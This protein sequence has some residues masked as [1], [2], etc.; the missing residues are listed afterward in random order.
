[1]LQKLGFHVRQSIFN[2]KR[3]L[4]TIITLALAISMIAGLFYYFDAF[5]RDALRTSVQFDTFTDLDL[6]H[7]SG[8]RQLDC[9][10]TFA[11]T[12][13]DVYNNI[14]RID[15]LKIESIYRYQSIGSSRAYV[16]GNHSN[17][18]DLLAQGLNEI[19]YFELLTYQFDESFYESK[20]FTQFFQIIEGTTPQA[21]N[22]ILVDL[23]V[24]AKLD[25]TV[26]ETINLS[27]AY[28]YS[29]A[30][31]Y[32]VNMTN[33]KV[34]GSYIPKTELDR[35]RI[36]NQTVSFENFY[37][38]FTQDELEEIEVQ[39]LYGISSAGRV[40]PILSYSSFTSDDHSFQQYYRDLLDAVG[41]ELRYVYFLSGYGVNID[42]DFTSFFNIYPPDRT[43]E[44][45]VTALRR[46][47]PPQVY[48]IDMISEPLQELFE[49]SNRLRI[50]SQIINL[51]IL[52]VALIVG[53]F[54]SK[55][56]TQ[57]KVDEFLLLR[58]K[59]VS[60]RMVRRQILI[61]SF[62]NG[63]VA[64]AIGT[65]L[66][67]VT[68][69]GH[70]LW[71]RPMI[72]T[73]FISL[74]VSLFAKQSSILISIALGVL[75]SLLTCISSIRYVNQLKIS[76]LLTIIE[77]E[78]MDIEFDEQS[79]FKST[80]MS[81][82]E[83]RVSIRKRKKEYL[84]IVEEKQK[85]EKK[86]SILFLTIALLPLYYF[87][88]I[89]I[90]EGRTSQYWLI[91]LIEIAK[92]YFTYG[93][94]SVLF[95]ISAIF[96]TIGLVRLITR[97]APVI[98]GR[99]S[100]FLGRIFLREKS[101]LLGLQMMKKK[102]YGKVIMLL[103][104]F[105][106]IF[107]HLNVMAYSFHAQ[108]NVYSNFQTGSDLKVSFNFGPNLTNTEDFEEFVQDIKTITK[109][110]QKL[111]KDAAITYE[112]RHRA[113]IH[114]YQH[115]VN[116]SSY[117]D[118]ALDGK[119]ILP[120]NEFIP[121]VMELI[122]FNLNDP[123]ED[124]IPGAI[125]NQRYLEENLAEIGDIANLD[126][127][128][129]DSR[130]P[131][132]LAF[133]NG[134]SL[135]F[136]IVEVVEYFPGVYAKYL[137]LYP[138]IEDEP[139]APYE[140]IV[141]DVQDLPFQGIDYMLHAPNIQVLINLNYEAESDKSVI[142]DDLVTR[143]EESYGGFSNGDFEFYIDKWVS[144]QIQNSDQIDPL[145]VYKIGY[146]IFVVV[147]IQV[148]LGLPILLASVRRKE[149][150]FYGILMSRGF[151]KRGIFRFILGE[152]FVIYFFSI[153]GG[154]L[155]GLISSTLTILLGSVSNP[156]SFALQFRIFLNPIDLG[157]ILASVILASLLIFLLGFL[158]DTQKSIS[159]YLYKF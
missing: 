86:W 96:L 95:V 47:I 118:F 113:Y 147:L 146:L 60:K 152:L 75:L 115:Y 93:Y 71:V 28:F 25:L 131:I 122:E 42:R 63:L 67:F 144:L 149:Q 127:R 138:T 100:R 151:G 73:Q 54:A 39:D 13:D 110:S 1:M 69:F 77:Q 15:E 112:H 5:E 109:N 134:F 142:E 104:V 35:Y 2:V 85:K 41:S 31:E 49:K 65:G 108:K 125:V 119:K 17:R 46:V 81:T 50:I 61:D 124:G 107:V 48:I 92:S 130:L 33:L 9:S 19:E 58:S 26:G 103:G 153:I 159:D 141:V 64:S 148:A 44:I 116:L 38:Y 6:L 135:P 84:D 57:N 98:L 123:Y 52:I 23:M 51:P 156:Y 106:S 158:Y 34:V 82:K 14:N 16:Y 154:L 111:I 66:G 45:G 21:N 37:I 55:S 11:F 129:Y 29:Y 27:T 83:M 68:F 121:K 3:S 18:P 117:L 79:V 114:Q 102:Q 59:G 88:F 99:M 72:Y 137:D 20:R 22:E 7:S 70:D 56:S 36:I 145:L 126:Y 132:D 133:I 40:T 140:H 80:D 101:Y 8:I 128:Y 87:L 78:D 10:N 105:T 150:H 89:L 155:M 90:A 62:I 120:D 32:L 43:V 30:H 12:D 97:E 157:V 143:T 4:M 53:S 91:R 74:E 94:S 136:R 139:N 76:E 24:A